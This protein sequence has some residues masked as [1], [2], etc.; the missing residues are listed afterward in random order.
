[1]ELRYWLCLHLARSRGWICQWDSTEVSFNWSLPQSGESCCLRDV[2]IWLPS[3]SAA[4]KGWEKE[5]SHGFIM[6]LPYV[7]Y[8]SIKN[9]IN[10]HIDT[11]CILMYI[12]VVFSE[13]GKVSAL[14][15]KFGCAAGLVEETSNTNCK[16]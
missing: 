3:P 4:Q 15:M 10:F 6:S 8:L 9:N 11:V 2:C 12:M 16:V 14:I 1:M 5:N 7:N 13:V